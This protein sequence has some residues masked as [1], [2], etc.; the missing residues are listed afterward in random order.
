MSELKEE[1]GTASK[2]SKVSGKLVPTKH[3]NHF[4]DEPDNIQHKVSVAAE[5]LDEK[6]RTLVVAS[7]N[8]DTKFFST[9][10]LLV[11]KG[12]EDTQHKSSH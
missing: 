1:R 10:M 3:G 11:W 12:R 4:V 5:D 2:V 9:C 7:K 6:I 8:K